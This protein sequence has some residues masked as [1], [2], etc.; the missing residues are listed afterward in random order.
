[1]K[2]ESN[3]GPQ[4]NRPQPAPAPPVPT[5]VSRHPVAQSAAARG[6]K[7]LQIEE[8]QQH[9][10]YPRQRRDGG[11]DIV[12]STVGAWVDYGFARKL[13]Q[14]LAESNRKLE[15]IV[16]VVSA[17]AAGDMTPESATELAQRA[18]TEGENDP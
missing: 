2:H 9:R 13:M 16:D 6:R 15:K 17:I 10:F 18:V 4:Q 7:R 8:L 12:P 5:I 11:L 3:Q 1:M 14:D